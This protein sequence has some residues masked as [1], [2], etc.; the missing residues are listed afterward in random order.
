LRRRVEAHLKRK[1]EGRVTQTQ[2]GGGGDKSGGGGATNE[3]TYEE[4]SDSDEE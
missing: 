1:E 2:G 3:K 4:L